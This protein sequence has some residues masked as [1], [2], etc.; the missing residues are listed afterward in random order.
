LPQG[1]VKLPLQAGYQLPEHQDYLVL[2]HTAKVRKKD[3]T[4]KK[5]RNYF[6]SI[7]LIFRRL[8][9]FRFSNSQPVAISHAL[10]AHTPHDGGKRPVGHLCGFQVGSEMG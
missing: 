1:F 5:K 7:L 9:D 2:I 8:Y 10:E 3:E 6:W 4:T